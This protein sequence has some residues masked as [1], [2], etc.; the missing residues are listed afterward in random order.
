[1]CVSGREVEVEGKRCKSAITSDISAVVKLQ[2][3]SVSLLTVA[4]VSPASVIF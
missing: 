2:W 4:P 1:M 3:R